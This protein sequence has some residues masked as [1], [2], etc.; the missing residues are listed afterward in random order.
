MIERGDPLK[1]IKLG[2][3]SFTEIKITDNTLYDKFIKETNY[4]VNVWSYNFPFLWSF[5]QSDART[6]LWKIIDDLLF[7]FGYTKK[8]TL[9]LVCLPF[10]K[11]NPDFIVK[12]LHKALNFCYEYN[13]RK[14]SKTLVRTLNENQLDFLKNSKYYAEYFKVKS[15][16][17]LEHHFIIN[18]ILELKGKKFANARYKINKFN[19]EFPNA[20]IRSYNFKD[21]N[22]ILKLNEYWESTSGENYKSIWGNI[23]YTEIIKNYDKLNH[24][25]LVI[26]IY[27]KIHGMV[28]GGITADGE[29]WGSFL[30]GNRNIV[31]I[32]EKLIKEFAHEINKVNPNVKY[33]NMGSDM[34]TGGLKTFKEKFNPV[35]NYKRYKLLLK[36]KSS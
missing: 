15:L 8:D 6:V 30:K 36:K 20:I 26:E 17:G 24:I 10:G 29:S 4:P 9:Y 27:N 14:S 11:G 1:T 7:T 35:F 5:S 18:D 32:N 16:K 23:C 2:D 12:A 22:E 28:S 34:G 21:F 13:N 19:R 3:W 33:V 25:I 31:G